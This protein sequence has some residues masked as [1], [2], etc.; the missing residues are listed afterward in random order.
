MEA[1]PE[2]LVL[3]Q[4]ASPEIQRCLGAM[5]AA[6]AG[7]LLAELPAATTAAV[8]LPL[9]HTVRD[10]L[11][12]GL[13]RDIR[14]EV[15]RRLSFPA[16]SVGRLMEAV[17][18]VIGEDV[19]RDSALESLRMA[20]APDAYVVDREQRLVGVLSRRDL[21]DPGRRSP[22]EQ[23][24]PDPVRLLATLGWEAA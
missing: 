19:P 12:A 22:R 2:A 1:R 21:E 7:S 24:V 18:T 13:P 11:I 4:M 3:A 15:R 10:A 20:G 5:D 16:E 9:E 23:I 14:Q 8:M 17:P 6:L